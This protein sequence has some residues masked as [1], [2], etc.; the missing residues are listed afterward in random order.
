MNQ[1]NEKQALDVIKAALDLAT[2]KG[3]FS[4]LDE[5]F[6]VIQAFN[7]VSEKIVK[8]DE[9]DAISSGQ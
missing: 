7:V 5:S 1:M 3:V 6:A 9:S 2:Q 4:R 8:K